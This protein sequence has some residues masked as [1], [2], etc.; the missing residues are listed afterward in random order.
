VVA[1][2]VMAKIGKCCGG[3]VTASAKAKYLQRQR[4]S[5][6]REN[7]MLKAGRPREKQRAWRR[8]MKKTNIDW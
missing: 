1:A 5:A 4:Q 3:D 6:A 7:D 8:N 2:A